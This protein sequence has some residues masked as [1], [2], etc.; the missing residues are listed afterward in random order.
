MKGCYDTEDEKL[1][2][3]RVVAIKLVDRIDRYTIK[4]IL[5]TNNQYVD[6][7]ASTTSLVLI[8][9]EDEETI[10]IIHKLTFPSYTYHLHSILSYIITNDD[11][12]HNWYWYIY[13]YLKDQSIPHRYTKNDRLRLRRIAMKYIIISDVLYKRSFNGTLLRFLT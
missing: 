6:A 5:R 1:K 12:F 10:L 4:T 11:A 7:M 8:K 9:L 13:G 2:P 3:Y